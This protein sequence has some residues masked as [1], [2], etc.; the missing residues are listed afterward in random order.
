MHI[1]EI[2][3]D[4]TINIS[5]ALKTKTLPEAIQLVYRLQKTW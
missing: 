1:K 2:R 3:E 5:H 4:V